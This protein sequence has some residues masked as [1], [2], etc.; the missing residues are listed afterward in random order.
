MQVG[1]WTT[2]EVS[3]RAGRCLSCGICVEICP[4]WVH[5]REGDRV[6]SDDGECVGCGL[7]PQWCPLEVLSVRL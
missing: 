3:R 5:P 1:R 4:Y 2:Y 7:C 6:L